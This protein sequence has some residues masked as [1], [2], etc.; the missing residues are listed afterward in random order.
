MVLAKGS[1]FFALGA[2]AGSLG[3]ALDGATRATL[4]SSTM[5]LTV[6]RLTPSAREIARIPV[7]LFFSVT[8]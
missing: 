6:L 2:R 4:C 7:P 3:N 8:T 1:T 5:A